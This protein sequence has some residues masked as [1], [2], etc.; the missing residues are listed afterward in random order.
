MRWF[1][2]DRGGGFVRGYLATPEWMS[3]GDVVSQLAY[4][5]GCDALSLEEMLAGEET[6]RSL[7]RWQAGDDS[8]LE[9]ADAALQTILDA[10]DA[11][12]GD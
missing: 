12:D 8:A 7:K 5:E 3:R 6:Y 4:S 11:I 10:E 1:I 2:F 9:V